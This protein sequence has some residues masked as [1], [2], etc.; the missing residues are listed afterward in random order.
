MLGTIE[1]YRSHSYSSSARLNQISSRT[2]LNLSYYRGRKKVR[3]DMDVLVVIEKSPIQRYLVVLPTEVLIREVRDL[4]NR[5]RY[6]Q[7]LA[8]T[9]VRGKLQRQ[10]SEGELPNISADLILSERSA[11]WDLKK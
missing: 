6:S 10:I 4:I 5:S 7:A 8:V 11:Y 2:G 1:I 3:I 9:F